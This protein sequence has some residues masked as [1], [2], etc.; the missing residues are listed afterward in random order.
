MF[1]AFALGIM[2]TSQVKNWEAQLF[3]SLVIK[4]SGWVKFGILEGKVLQVEPR[5]N[6][7]GKDDDC[8]EQAGILTLSYSSETPPDRQLPIANLFKNLT[9]I[10]FHIGGVGQGARR[11]C[12]SRK[13]RDRAPW[14]RGS[15]L[16]PES[17]NELWEL[18]DTPKQFQQLFRQ[19][20]TDFSNAL[21]ELIGSNGGQPDRNAPVSRDSWTEAVDANCKI[22]VCSG[23]DDFGKPYALAVLHSKDFKVKDKRGQETYDGDLCGVVGREVKPSPVW[24]A[25]LGDYQV[26]TVFGAIQNPRK[27]YIDALCRKADEY[28]S[29]YPV[30][31]K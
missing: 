24:I 23:D 28:A 31:K 20:L 19:R 11:P 14:Y 26:V 10:M 4:G 21:K 12:Y 30:E 3:G 29:I 5:P 6:F 7:K 2:S 18:P 27:S 1:R 13:T 25:D 9:W 8:G 17:E 15:T 22:V 16:I